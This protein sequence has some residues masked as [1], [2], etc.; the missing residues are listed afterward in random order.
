MDFARLFVSN[1]LT[2]FSFR[3]VAGCALS[4]QKACL[5]WIEKPFEAASRR[6]GPRPWGSGWAS[7]LGSGDH[8]YIIVYLSVDNNQCLCFLFYCIAGD[9][10]EL[11]TVCSSLQRAASAR[12]RS[13]K[14]AGVCP[15][16]LQKS[17]AKLR[18]LIAIRSANAG[19][20]RCSPGC[21][22]IQ[23]C[24]S[25]KSGRLGPTSFQFKYALNWDC[26]PRPARKD[27]Q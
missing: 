19:T 9:L 24:S 17:R 3:A 18:G 11:P 22:R 16:S 1:D 4:T 27:H 6:L 15:A 20:L 26:A 21:H 25:L 23:A 8:A 5:E 13:A 12:A 7:G 2:G 14:C 10:V